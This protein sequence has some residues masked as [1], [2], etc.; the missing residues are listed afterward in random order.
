MSIGDPLTGAFKCARARQCEPGQPRGEKLLGTQT[1]AVSFCS[2]WH[3][4]LTGVALHLVSK[5]YR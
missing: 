5:L 1:Y 3:G 4:T 2:G